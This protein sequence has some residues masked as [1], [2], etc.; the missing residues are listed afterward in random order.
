MSE[1]KYQILHNFKRNNYKLIKAQ[2]YRDL[3]EAILLLNKK[4]QNK[5]LTTRTTYTGNARKG[6]EAVV[7][8]VKRKK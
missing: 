2:T 3:E 6:Y 4:A 7:R 8:I 1:K 5:G